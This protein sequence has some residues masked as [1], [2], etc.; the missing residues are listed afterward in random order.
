ME[1][2]L[3]RLD[4][5]ELER[6]TIIGQSEEGCQVRGNSGVANGEEFVLSIL[7]CSGYLL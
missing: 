3:G 1:A 5:I 4:T 7:Q 2:R 6:T